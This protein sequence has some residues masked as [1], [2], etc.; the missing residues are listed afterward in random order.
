MISFLKKIFCDEGNYKEVRRVKAELWAG[1]G[2][3]FENYIQ[4]LENDYGDR[5][6]AFYGYGDMYARKVEDKFKRERP[7]LYMDALEWVKG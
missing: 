7:D 3:C 5:K 2:V 6:L 1:Q 4:Y